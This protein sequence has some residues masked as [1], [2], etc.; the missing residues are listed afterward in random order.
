MLLLPQLV[1]GYEPLWCVCMYVCVCMCVCVCVC[2]G[3]RGYVC[4]RSGSGSGGVVVV[5]CCWVVL[6]F[7]RCEKKI[8]HKV[9]MDV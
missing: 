4:G 7:S 3:V 6:L 8:A 1:F 9:M 5:C 2:V